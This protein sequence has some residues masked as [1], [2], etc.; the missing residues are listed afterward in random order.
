[1]VNVVSGKTL[2]PSDP[3][4]TLEECAVFE[5]VLDL[6][7]ER[8]MKVSVVVTFTAGDTSTWMK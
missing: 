1:M 8:L 5:D 4:V 7:D 2:D 6:V 3:G